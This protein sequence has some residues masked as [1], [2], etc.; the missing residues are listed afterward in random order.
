MFGFWK[1]VVGQPNGV[2]HLEFEVHGIGDS[3]L[4]YRLRR[5]M[6]LV[7]LLLRRRAGIGTL[8]EVDPS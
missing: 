1:Q 4:S 6:E 8:S 5:K 2:S 7:A 3:W